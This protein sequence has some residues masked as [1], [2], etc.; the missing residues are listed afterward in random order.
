VPPVVLCVKSRNG[1][2]QIG[3]DG[4][5]FRYP[6]GKPSSRREEERG[7]LSADPLFALPGLTEAIVEILGDLGRRFR[8]KV[9]GIGEPAAIQEVADPLDHELNLGGRRRLA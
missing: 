5:T 8:T 6:A 4:G 2:E 9:A 3:P 1:G 7:R